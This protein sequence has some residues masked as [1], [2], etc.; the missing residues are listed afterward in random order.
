M[1]LADDGPGLYKL[2]PAVVQRCSKC[3]VQ[4]MGKL[5]E[6]FQIEKPYPRLEEQEEPEE[7]FEVW[8]GQLLASWF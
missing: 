7:E 6:H 2:M 3:M 1:I 5:S 4:S 8:F